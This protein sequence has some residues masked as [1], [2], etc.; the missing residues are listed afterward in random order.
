MTSCGS[1]VALKYD[2]VVFMASDTLLSYGSMAKMPNIQRTKILGKYTAVCCTGDFADFQDVTN[3]LEEKITE[4]ELEE[5]NVNITPP[6]LFCYLHRTIYNKRCDFEPAMCSWVVMGNEDGKTFL[7]GLDSIGTKWEDNAVCSGY[8]AHIALPIIRRAFDQVDG[9]L[10]SRDA[11]K[12]VIE[13]CMRSLF[14]RE[15]RTINRIQVT[16]ATADKITISEPYT[17]DTTWDHSGFAFEKTA[18]LR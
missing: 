18:I 17:L 9:G 13:D 6:E 8:G 14:Y 16:E 5:S 12:A 10:L 15:C 11:A 3:S 1:V 4:D 7:G 2:G